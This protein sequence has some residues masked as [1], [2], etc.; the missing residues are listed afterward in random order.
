[1][2][3]FHA[4]RRLLIIDDH[5]QVHDDFFQILGAA[6]TGLTV[7]SATKSIGPT[8]SSASESHAPHPGMPVFSIAN[9]E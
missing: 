9:L 2:V 3:E 7:T 1:M 6:N 8:N 4:E 5:Q